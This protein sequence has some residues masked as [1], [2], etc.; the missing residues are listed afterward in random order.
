MNKYLIGSFIVGLMAVVGLL[1]GNAVG[2]TT[3]TTP[4]TTPPTT[5][6]TTPP[7]T[8]PTTTT[9]ATTTI[10]NVSIVRQVSISNNGSA[11]IQGVVVTPPSA[12]D[13][14][15]DGIP[16]TTTGT[17][18]TDGTATGTTMVVNTW[19]GNWT[20][21]I[22]TNTRFQRENSTNVN[23]GVI[24]A[25]DRVVIVG[26]V[27]DTNSQI[28]Q[29]TRIRDRSVQRLTINGTVTG[30]DAAGSSFAMTGTFAG[31]STLI[32]V[33]QPPNATTTV[34]GSGVTTFGGI[35]E[36]MR[37]RVTGDLNKSQ[38]TLFAQ[39][40]SVTAT[41]TSGAPTGTAVRTVIANG[42]AFTP[43][44]VTVQAGETVRWVNGDT[45]AHTVTA[46]NGSFD[47]GTLSP[48]EEFFHTFTETGTFSYF[49]RIHPEMVASVTVR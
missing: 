3:T 33:R 45:V 16:T 13:G 7:T 2:Q 5:T 41:S 1:G 31:T 24:Q 46:S 27:R 8:T 20:V 10:R 17:P 28:I 4:T 36:G 23:S 37:V 25:G 32:N 29:A 14:T 12:G 6:T 11:Q 18:G 15:D 26:Q 39:S 22:A 49:C 19:G 43:G 40:V 21:Q 44:S 38:A 48:G 9:P 35:A 47:S 30:V 42:L 34:S